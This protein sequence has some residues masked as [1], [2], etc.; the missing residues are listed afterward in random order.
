MKKYLDLIP[1]CYIFA[2]LNLMFN[3][4]KGEAYAQEN[5]RAIHK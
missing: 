5:I 2:A 4:L 1:L 3:N